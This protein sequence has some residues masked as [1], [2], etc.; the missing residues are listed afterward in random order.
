MP[1]RRGDPPPRIL[2]EGRPGSGKTTVAR[3]LVDRLR[4]AG[5]L[6]T[7]FTTEEVRQGRSRV[8]FAVDAIDGQRGLL[9]HVDY[10]GPVTVGKY[11]VDT[12]ELERIALPS[13][14]RPRGVVVIDELGKMELA[15]EPFRRAVTRVF[16]R[17]IPILATVHAYRH[18]FTDGLKSRP[19]VE[20]LR[21]SRTNRDRLPDELA[22]RLGA[23]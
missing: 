23:D 13:L 9:A 4:D 11:G 14:R 20:V 5:V 3:R 12:G 15:S 2:L 1:R 17:R 18:P 16:E 21:V 22:A 19:D 8:G 7:G 10:R 6:V